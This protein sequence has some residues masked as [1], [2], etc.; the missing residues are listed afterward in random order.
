MNSVASDATFAQEW[1]PVIASIGVVAAAL[2]AYTVALL[3]RRQT[4][5]HWR[6]ANRQDRFT[7]IATQLADDSP[8]VRIAGVYALEALTDDWLKKPPIPRRY[9]RFI[10]NH[11]LATE[12]TDQPHLN[13][14]YHRPWRNRGEARKQD[15]ERGRR[16]AQTCIN[17]LCAYLRL[18]IPADTIGADTIAKTIH[19]RRARTA[20]GHDI[21][22]EDHHTHRQNDHQVRAS[23]IRTIKNHLREGPPGESWSQL[24]FDFSGATLVDADFRGATFSGD[25]NFTNVTFAGTRTNFEAATFAAEKFT[26]FIDAVFK[27]DH[28]SFSR[29]EFTGGVVAFYNA[30][31]LSAGDQLKYSAQ[32]DFTSAKFSTTVSPF[33]ENCQFRSPLTSFGRAEFSRS[34][35][36]DFATFAGR[37]TTFQYAKFLGPVASF[38]DVLFEAGACTFTEAEFR[39]QTLDF[40]R[41]K[42]IGN[43]TARFKEAHIECEE[44]RFED[45]ELNRAMR[46][47]WPPPE[48][49]ID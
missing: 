28:T 16:Q 10:R 7:T 42:F 13:R 29:T 40:D 6:T 37:N 30:Q 44:M 23:I 22:T 39:T 35:S 41:A 24:D 8:A 33:F 26:Q 25:T 19:R 5:K 46:D 1:G 15:I 48:A 21:E 18:P 38:S 20:A 14:W 43:A 9:P 47:L 12:Q 2:I 45:P 49:D 31:F 4:E 36:F 3:N 11:I 32:T 34:T 27:A 17:V